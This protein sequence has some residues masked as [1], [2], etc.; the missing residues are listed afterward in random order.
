MIRN[1]GGEEGFSLKTELHEVRRIMLKQNNQFIM[2]N[3]MTV[4][5]KALFFEDPNEVGPS[6]QVQ[7]EGVIRNEEGIIIK[8]ADGN[9]YLLKINE[10]KMLSFDSEGKTIDLNLV[11][12]MEKN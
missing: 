3:G 9:D 5:L 1:V 6:D 12:K 7:F 8:K 10:P 2:K 11:L 4:D